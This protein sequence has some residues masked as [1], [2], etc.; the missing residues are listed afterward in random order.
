[1][2]AYVLLIVIAISVSVV[3]YSFLNAYVPRPAEK[4]P[5]DVS[6]IIQDYG[7]MENNIFNLTVKN[8]G[9]HSIDGMIVHISNEAGKPAV[10]GLDLVGKS[11]TN[12][13]IPFVDK[14]NA[15]DSRTFYFD[16][17]PHGA[18]TKINIKPFKIG[19]NII[20]CDA[21]TVQDIVC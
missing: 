21:V 18:I 3:V 19:K 1:M 11:G 13:E 12:G 7:C 16:Y 17:S 20:I 6:L 8:Q 9:L 10:F 4:C 2:I 5:D 15:S 14:L